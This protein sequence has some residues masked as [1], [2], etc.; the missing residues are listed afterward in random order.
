[1]STTNK[2]GEIHIEKMLFANEKEF[3][4]FLLKFFEINSVNV[5]SINGKKHIYSKNGKSFMSLYPLEQMKNF[6]L[7]KMSINIDDKNLSIDIKGAGL[8]KK[9]F[10]LKSYIA[11]LYEKKSIV[12]YYSW[13]SYE[14]DEDKTTK[15]WLYEQHERIKQH[16]SGV[17]GN[18]EEIENQ[19]VKQLIKSNA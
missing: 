12:S 19:K 6:K 7:L 9:I 4:D 14:G 16:Q 17:F 13:P 11:D 1:M 8:I 18:I 15:E 2:Y 3:H 5:D 10:P